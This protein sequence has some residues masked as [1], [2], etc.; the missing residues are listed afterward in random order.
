MLVLISD[1]HVTDATTAINVDPSA[2]TLL[3]REIAASYADRGAQEMHLVLL[4]DIYDLVRTDYWLS[5]DVPRDRRPWGVGPGQRLDPDTFMN[6]DHPMLE[7]QFTRILEAI[8]A[9]PGGAALTGLVRGLPHP[10]GETPRVTYV[11]GN[12]DRVFNNFPTLTQRVSDEL[13]VEVEFTNQLR[14][15]SYGT[16]ARHGHEWDKDCHAW[17]FITKVLKRKVDRFDPSTYKVMAIGEVITAE[18]M[19]G[20]V[21]RV[22]TALDL[23]D[24]NDRLFLKQ[25]KDVNN[26]RPMSE[27]LPWLK[28]FT[29]GRDAR[30]LGI[31]QKALIGSLEDLLASSLAREWDKLKPDLLL[32]RDTIDNLQTALKQLR[33]PGG[34]ASLGGKAS[35]LRWLADIK[36]RVWTALGLDRDAYVSGALQE[37]KAGTLPPQTQYVAYGHTHVA[38]HDCFTAAREGAVQFYINTG[39]YLPLIER[40]EADRGYWRAH[41][42]TMVFCYRSDEDVPDRVGDGPTVDVWDG[43]R[44][45]VFT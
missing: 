12:H 31:L 8:L 29:E 20:V 33:A 17:E 44:R 4:G 30:F 19:G 38:R 3:G 18:L 41:N 27:A 14:A 37:F 45:K 35:A 9:S 11:I 28:W 32:S 13:D 25:I 15:P 7:E 26:L 16:A 36:G 22:R 1:L 39:T 42:M 40:A 2:F 24:P 6:P 5:H 23:N 43:I 10:A 34:L 21:Y